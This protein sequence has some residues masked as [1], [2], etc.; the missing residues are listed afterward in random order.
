MTDANS[1][2]RRPTDEALAQTIRDAIRAKRLEALI[3]VELRLSQD[4][5]NR[6]SPS[7]RFE[8]FGGRRVLLFDGLPCVLV[9]GARAPFTVKTIE[10][11][12]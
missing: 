8:P 12:S 6:L 10:P 1:G 5:W 7:M 3:P 11:R 2:E 4:V 9:I